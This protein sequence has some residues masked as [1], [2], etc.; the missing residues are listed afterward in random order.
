[1]MCMFTQ[2]NSSYTIRNLY[3]GFVPFVIIT[4]QLF[5]HPWFIT[6]FVTKDVRRVPHSKHEL[7]FKAPEFIPV[8][9]GFRD[10]RSLA[11]CAIFVD[12]WLSF[13]PVNFDHVLTFSFTIEYLQTFLIDKIHFRSFT[14]EEFMLRMWNPSYILCYKS[15]DKSWMRKQLEC[16]YDKRNKTVVICDTDTS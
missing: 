10:A 5:S 1:M 13:C 8:S 2:F 15:G 4:F 14:H 6:G 12:R 3:H 7:I 11:L 16:D 9:G